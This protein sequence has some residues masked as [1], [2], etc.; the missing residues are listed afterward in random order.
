MEIKRSDRNTRKTLRTRRSR[1][2]QTTVT[3]DKLKIGVNLLEH[4]EFGILK[5]KQNLT[6]LKKY[7]DTDFKLF[8]K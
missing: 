1:F 6:P 4:G 3:V 8:R 5:C 7:F 2:S